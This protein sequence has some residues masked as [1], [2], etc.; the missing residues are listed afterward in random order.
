MEQ[1]ASKALEEFRLLVGRAL[2]ISPE[3]ML[4]REKFVVKAAPHHA[5]GRKKAKTADRTP[6]QRAKR[7]R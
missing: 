5:Q 1:S 4:R 6:A 2:S 3:E 7:R